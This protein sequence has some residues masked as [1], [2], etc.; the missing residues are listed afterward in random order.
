M[1][2]DGSTAPLVIP[3]KRVLLITKI[4]FY[5]ASS[6][7][8]PMAQ[9]QMVPFYY[10]NLSISNGFGGKVVDIK[11]GFP[12]AVWSSN[13]NVK[14]VNKANSQTI[15]GTLQCR[16]VGLLAPPEAVTVPLD[17]LLLLDK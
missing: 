7:D 10:K 14:V 5:I 17:L 4:I 6:P 13:F 1:G 3:G 12:L 16:I 2:L 9:F 11:S 8:V 15:P